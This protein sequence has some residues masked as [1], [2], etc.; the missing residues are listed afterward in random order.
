MINLKDAAVY[1]CFKLNQDYIAKNLCINRDKPESCCEGSCELE[2]ALDENS[3]HGN[4]A[5]FNFHD[6]KEFSPYLQLD[7]QLKF[8]FAHFNSEYPVFVKL[9]YQYS[10]YTSIFHPPNLIS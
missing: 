8:N 2:K 9:Y 1:I 10:N 6:N 7:K 4:K 3:E 5:P